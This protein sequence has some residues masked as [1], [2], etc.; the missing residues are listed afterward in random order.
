MDATSAAP[1][2]ELTRNREH[3]DTRR[4]SHVVMPDL[5][6]PSV[7]PVDE[8]I[9]CWFDLHARPLASYASRRVGPNLARDVVAETFRLAF[10]Q[11]DHFDGT[12]GTERMWLF[13]ITTNLIRRHWRAEERRL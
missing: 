3:P 13:G 5:R 6:V 1:H 11:Y 10:E 2:T 4:A 12:R 7:R 8:A 9:A